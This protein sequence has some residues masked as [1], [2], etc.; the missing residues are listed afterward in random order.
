MVIDF[1]TTINRFTLLD[2]YPLP[3]IDNLVSQISKFRI[4]SK[5]DLKHAYYQIPLDKMDRP[6]TAFQA[7][8]CLYQFTRLPF[9]LTNA[10]ACFQRAMNDV[11]EKFQLQSTFAYLDDIIICGT[12][13]DDHDSNL[14]AFMNCAKELGITLREDKC[15]YFDSLRLPTLGITFR[16]AKYAR[17]LSE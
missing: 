3:I 4:F 11:I 15:V 12:D 6:F 7:N 17:I 13:S 1:S 2:A 8:N 5:L 10:V 16:T 14:K 9:G